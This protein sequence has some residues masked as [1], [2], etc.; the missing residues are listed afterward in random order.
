[1]RVTKLRPN[2]D[3]VKYCW[4]IQ[5]LLWEVSMQ[6][7]NGVALPL[8]NHIFSLSISKSG[9]AVGQRSGSYGQ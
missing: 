7:L 6:T 5:I 1:M 2:P 4:W 3:K 8:K 9:C